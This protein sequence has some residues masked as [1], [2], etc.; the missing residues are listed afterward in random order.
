MSHISPFSHAMI[1]GLQTQQR[2]VVEKEKQLRR[3]QAQLKDVSAEEDPEHQVESAED[4]HTIND[5]NSRD[6]QKRNQGKHQPHDE[7]DEEGFN[8]DLTA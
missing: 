8:L 6:K 4:S 1:Q 3:A 2:M 5:Q 7:K